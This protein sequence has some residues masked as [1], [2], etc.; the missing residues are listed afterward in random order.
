[1]NKRKYDIAYFNISSAHDSIGIMTAKKCGVEEVIVHS[2]SS[3]ADGTSVIKTE[4][5]KTLNKLG[6]LVLSKNVDKYLACSDKA[7]KWLF[8]SYIYNTSNYE[9]I[10]N[11]IDT[12]KFKYNKTIRDKI[13]R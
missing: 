5:K 2:H 4:I 1:M 11:R 6:K 9:I 3:N 13:R 7:A 10:Y 12:R 8:P